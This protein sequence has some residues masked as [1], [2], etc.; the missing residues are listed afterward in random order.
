MISRLLAAGLVA[1][2]LTWTPA[3]A[4]NPSGRWSGSWTSFS[5]GHQ[6][7]LRARIRPVNENTYRALFVGRFAKVIPFAY[8]AKLTR[9]PG[10][11]NCYQSSTRLPLMGEYRMTASITSHSFRANYSSK[12][13]RGVFQMSR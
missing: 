10:T 4:A 9:V 6:G 8:P 1:L 3:D 12:K 13:D 11:C 2:A 7:P 5:T